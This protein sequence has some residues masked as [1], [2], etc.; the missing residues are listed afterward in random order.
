MK[1]IKSLGL[2]TDIML[3]KH[4]AIV[5]HKKEYIVVKSPENPMYFW[6]NLLIYPLGPELNDINI[7]RENFHTEFAANPEIQH[8]SFAWDIS[9]K[10]NS[11]KFLDAGFDYEETAVLT[12]EKSLNIKHFNTKITIKKIQSKY[13]WNDI[14]DF[15]LDVNSEGF[16]EKYFRPFI[17]KQ[18]STYRKLTEIG[19][20]NWYGAYIN[21]KLV[22]DLG[23]YWENKV[24]IFRDIK[25]HPDFRKT[26]ISQTLMNFAAVDSQ[27]NR[28]VI[29]TD[30]YGSAINMYKSIGFAFNE[31]TASLCWYDKAKWNKQ[32]T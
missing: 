21:G 28:F 4:S 30:E 10:V 26:G 17:I 11:D 25:T 20:G 19:I 27:C 18:F 8:M 3:Y 32:K 9:G 15:Q 24:A 16:N 29:Q 2:I 22:A 13:E 7:W 31:V 12:A 23:L 1:T 14:I 6:G 5:E